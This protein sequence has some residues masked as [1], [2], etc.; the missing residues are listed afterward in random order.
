MKG[1]VL[2]GAMCT[3][4]VW[5][6]LESNLSEHNV[7][8]V[9]YP[10]DIIEKANN[11]SDITQWVYETYKEE[12]FDF[13]VGHS[14]GGTIGLELAADFNLSCD[15]MIFI[16]T[17]LKPAKAFYRNLML[18][19]NM[20]RYGEKVTSM[21]KGE[22]MYYGDSLKKSVREDFDYTD[23]IRRINSK[24][25]GIYGDRGQRDYSNRIRDLCLDHE[26][27][28]KIDFRFVEDSCH[29]PMIENPKALAD[30]IN[31]ILKE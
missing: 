23:Y 11:V 2:Y 30:I 28:S 12:S 6:A 10:H 27:A 13:V 16:E 5:D 31:S 18:A 24:I 14:M 26:I 9:E 15:K 17:N 1:L 25:Y 29:M 3:L 19:T 21:I 22:S 7:I 4:D 8:F 20:Q